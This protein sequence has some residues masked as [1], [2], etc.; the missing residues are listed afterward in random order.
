MQIT[1]ALE[2]HCAQAEWRRLCP[3]LGANRPG[4]GQISRARV[5]QIMSLLNLSADVQEEILA[6][7][8]AAPGMQ[9]VTEATVRALSANVSW[10]RQRELWSGFRRSRTSRIAVTSYDPRADDLVLEQLFKLYLV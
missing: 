7:S 8:E 2:A 1:T 5:T 9:S 6:E 10:S 4:L 3:R